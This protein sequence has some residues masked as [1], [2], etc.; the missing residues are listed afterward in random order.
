MNK[1]VGIA[2]ALLIGW[3]VDQHYNDG[4]FTDGLLSMLS[5]IRHSFGW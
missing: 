2:A 3:A 5:Q 1:V 4:H